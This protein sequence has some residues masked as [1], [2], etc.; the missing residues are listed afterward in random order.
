MSFTSRKALCAGVATLL[1]GS[2]ALLAAPSTASAEV[3]MSRSECIGGLWHVMTYDVTDP[4]NWVLQSDEPT[5][6][7]CGGA[8]LAIGF[9]DL[10]LGG[11][12]FGGF[13]GHGLDRRDHG[14]HDHPA[15]GAGGHGAEG[16]AR[17]GGTGTSGASDHGS[18]GHGGSLV[19]ALGVRNVF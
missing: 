6:Q 17:S 9:S 18:S 13:R 12:G 3:L 14:G 5:S 4:N 1:L 11:H 15:I 7:P 2:A 16:D 8:A 10:L 19:S